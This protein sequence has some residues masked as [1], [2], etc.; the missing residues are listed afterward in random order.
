M[1]TKK[2]GTSGRFGPRYGGVMRKAVAT[3][4]K[5]QKAAHACGRCGSMSV[6]RDGTAIWSCVKCGYSFAGGAYSPQ[7]GAGLGAAQ[8]LRAVQE[9][10]SNPAAAA[11]DKTSEE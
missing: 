10:L 4:E 1:A 11:S 7:T 9:K 6:Y 8:A 5:T 3:I 2:V